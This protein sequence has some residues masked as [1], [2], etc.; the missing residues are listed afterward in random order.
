M[1]QLTLHTIPEAIFVLTGSQISSCQETLK[2]ILTPDK[3][4]FI[5]IRKTKHFSVMKFYLRMIEKTE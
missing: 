2:E 5:V 4:Q 3:I 1:I